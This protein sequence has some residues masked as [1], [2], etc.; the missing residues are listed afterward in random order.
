MTVEVEFEYPTKFT[1][2]K[3]NA[4]TESVHPIVK[5][6]NNY[7]FRIKKP[8]VGISIN[9]STGI[10]IISTKAVAGNY[11]LEVDCIDS[12]S[13]KTYSTKHVIFIRDPKNPFPGDDEFTDDCEYK[14]EVNNTKTK[15]K[16]KSQKTH[17]LHKSVKS[18]KYDLS[19]KSISNNRLYNYFNKKINKD[20]NN[21]MV[22]SI[23]FTILITFLKLI[24]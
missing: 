8:F 24:S 12:I 18:H 20:N 6:L 2:S 1:F 10:I 3:I 14:S 15:N 19:D 21:F 4:K 23:I 9:P 16:N 11:V 5:G 13:N 17:K 7:V 22:V